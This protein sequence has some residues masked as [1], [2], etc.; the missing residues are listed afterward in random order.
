M[1]RSRALPSIGKNSAGFSYL[2]VL[3]LVA[4]MGAGLTLV[5]EIEATAS[6]RDKE[7]ELLAVGRQFRTALARYYDQPM[8]G[9]RNVY[10][11]SFDDLLQDNRVPGIRRH[12]RKIFVDP[13][14]GKAEWGLVKVG[15]RIVGIYSLSDKTPIKQ[16]GFDIDDTSFK[17]KEKYSDW[18]FTYPPALMIRPDGSINSS[19]SMQEG[20]LRPYVS[21]QTLESA[22]SNSVVGQSPS[23]TVTPL[24]TL[25]TTQPAQLWR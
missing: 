10:P 19:P 8:P 18:K 15:G 9:G 24:S 5:V 25:P 2:W 4:F 6:Q 13:M 22:T 11:V 1:G 16:D 21:S 3:L 17:D 14:T 23:G 20:A 7:R 12:L